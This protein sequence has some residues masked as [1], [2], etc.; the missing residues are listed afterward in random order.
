M[1][2][3]N[4][5]VTKQYAMSEYRCGHFHREKTF[6]LLRSLGVYSETGLNCL[7]FR[8]LQS[9]YKVNGYTETNE[10]SLPARISMFICAESDAAVIRFSNNLL[11]SYGV[12]NKESRSYIYS[13]LESPRFLLRLPQFA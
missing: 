1:Y 13:V 11:S 5:F 10:D 8:N 3:I 9:K 4:G 6:K 12:R 7:Y 2:R